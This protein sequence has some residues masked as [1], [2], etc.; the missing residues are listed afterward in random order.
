MKND[1]IFP[2]NPTLEY[3]NHPDKDGYVEKRLG[4]FG[5]TKREYFAAKALQG[6]LANSGPYPHSADTAVRALKYADILLEELD[7]KKP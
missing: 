1:P 7:K 4:F 2:I 6:L 5:L 3:Q